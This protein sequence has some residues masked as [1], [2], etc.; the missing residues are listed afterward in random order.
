LLQTLAL[1]GP[2]ATSPIVADLDGNGVNEVVVVTDF[3][4]GGA[5]MT[6][7]AFELSGGA[8]AEA[9]SFAIPVDDIGLPY[10]PLTG[11]AHVAVGDLQ[12]DGSPE[13]VVYSNYVLG[14]S[15]CSTLAC[16]APS[17]NDGR[18]TVLSGTTGSQVDALL[19]DVIVIGQPAAPVLGD[20]TGDGKPEIIIV[21][22][23]GGTGAAAGFYLLGASLTGSTLGTV[24]DTK[25]GTVSLA[26]P[27][28]LAELRSGHSG[29]ELVVAE[30]GFSSGKVYVC[31][32]ASGNANC[33]ESLALSTN[34]VRGLAVGDLD[35]DG[36]PE[37]VANGRG[38]NP[39][40]T[41]TSLSVV[42]TTGGTLAIG[43]QR[44]D[45]FLWNTPSIGDVDGDG[46]NEVVN[47]QYSENFDDAKSGNVQV[48]GFTG[49]A[50]TPEGDLTRQGTPALSTE[51]RGGGS[52]V[53]LDGDGRP[54]LVL[55]SA[56]GN[57][58]AV[59]FSTSSVPTQM[60]SLALG[61]AGPAAA[62][63]TPVAAGDVNGDGK[64][65]LVVGGADKN[66]YVLGAAGASVPGAP[67]S[68]GGTPGNGQVALSWTAPASQ[69]GSAISSYKVYRGT[70]PGTET[71]LASTPNATP[72]Y[73]DTTV[74]NGVT[75]YYQVSA[76]NGQGEGARSNEASATPMGAASPPSAPQGLQAR[77]GDQSI[78]LLWNAPLSDGGSPI[79]A[80]K[81]YRGTTSGSL[82]LLASG[83]CSGLGNVL[84]C[85]DTGL[86]NGVT[87]FY[88][89]S[90]ANGLGE[91]A[92]SAEASATPAA[93]SALA[94]RNYP[95]DVNNALMSST[96]EPGV[97]VNWVSGNVMMSAQSK[98]PLNIPPVQKQA[99]ITFNDAVDPPTATFTDVTSP[100]SRGNIDP[101]L[102]T[103]SLTGRT[104]AGGWDGHCSIL[105]YTD[106]DG[107]LWLPSADPCA[108]PGVDHPTIGVGKVAATTPP[109]PGT[110]PSVD[111]PRI[112]YYCAQPGLTT[113]PAECWR[114]LDGGNA[115]SPIAPPWTLNTCRGLHGK[116]RVS[117]VDGAAYVPNKNCLGHAGFAVTLD[118]GLT[119]S[120]RM[121]PGA[122]GSGRFD[123]SVAPARAGSRVYFAQAEQN[124]PFVG[125]TTD[126][127]LT[128]Q[129]VG[130][131]NGAPALTK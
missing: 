78:A 3:L 72:S 106:D 124:G 38:S 42:K 104:M 126:H 100:F 13:V 26:S 88:Q 121:N 65:D 52:L 70:S 81:V 103:D 91:G 4:Q 50:I 27:P 11:S 51:A 114:S 87:Y 16:S 102:T 32:P 66:L 59:R 125:V 86:T 25:V 76:V 17:L 46:K 63:F 92:R 47:V 112:W 75:Y 12:G 8:L 41:A 84:A 9:W 98:P 62:P 83:P 105:S 94:F 117:D 49:A 24:F 45:G 56:D 77:A 21:R 130:A 120:V 116:V 19:N 1:P 2:L 93:G 111:A 79:G 7:R 123:P 96:G 68:L 99:R 101:L 80:Y 14:A 55:G 71:F 108:L 60:W 34:A 15:A 82:S 5:L 118:N 23:T 10:A 58:V 109:T 20:V 64:A 57:L 36:A 115:F 107:V 54:E 129:D 67:T 95:G 89:V 37:I 18:L 31:K 40:L 122:D 43:A 127:G 128:W 110:W 53:D 35:G 74:T 113:G 119:W 131:G 97:G 90:A 69:G 22:Q 6:V 61:V 73:T 85:T 44:N 28:A 30:D 39:A 29:L 48:R 33:N